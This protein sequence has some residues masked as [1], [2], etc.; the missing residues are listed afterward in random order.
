MKRDERRRKKR[1]VR[2]V[3]CARRIS[4]G[5]SYSNLHTF[6]L[7]LAKNTLIHLIMNV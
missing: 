6:A 3:L 4:P 1:E 2:P 5:R 7:A